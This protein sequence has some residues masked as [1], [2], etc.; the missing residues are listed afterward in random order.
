[1]HKIAGFLSKLA[2]APPRYKVAVVPLPYFLEFNNTLRENQRF[3]GLD[4][5]FFNIIADHLGFEYEGIVPKDE[6]W[7]RKNNGTWTG[8]IGL[9]ASGSADMALGSIAINA[10][11]AEVVDFSTSY[12]AEETTF[13]IENPPSTEISLFAFLSIF[14][15]RVWI[16]F[17][18]AILIFGWQFYIFS[19]KKTEPI[20][21]CLGL[22][23]SV[24][25]QGFNVK[26]YSKK[27]LI[28]VVAWMFFSFMMSLSYSTKLL[29]YLSIP[30]QKVPIQTFDEM[31]EAVK[32]GT[33]K[34]ITW[35]QG[36]VIQFLRNSTQQ[37]LRN[38]GE[39]IFMNDWYQIPSE[40][41][42]TSEITQDCCVIRSRVEMQ[43]FYSPLNYKRKYMVSKENLGTWSI[44]IALSKRFCCKDEIN[45]VI[46]R[47]TS[48]GIYNKMLHDMSYKFWVI[49]VGN[50]KLDRTNRKTAKL[51]VKDM[52]GPLILVIIGFSISVAVFF[53]EVFHFFWYENKYKISF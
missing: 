13:A 22:F 50:E 29:S 33:H 27:E 12:S 9:V 25:G 52:L 53:G 28:L 20:R 2:M 15:F 14:D 21:I 51:R 19:G 31:A 37:N 32:K 11:R 18:L 7:G 48:A 10:P 43:L 41:A 30:L 6:E 16:C 42:S 3:G 24:I 49:N 46:S 1:M 17:F 45:K 26:F 35:K 4:G 36:N 39:H 44:A 38:L 40:F 47:L 23:G 34:C 8:L 5:D